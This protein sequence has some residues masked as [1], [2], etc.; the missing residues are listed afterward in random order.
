MNILVLEPDPSDAQ[1]IENCLHESGVQCKIKR[2]TGGELYHATVAEH[3]PQVIIAELTIPRF[4]VLDTLRA[5]RKEGTGP[6]WIIISGMRSDQQMQTALDA[7]ATEFVRKTNLSRLTKIIAGFAAEHPESVMESPAAAS[8]ALP[9]A[10]PQTTPLSEPAPQDEDRIFRQ[11]VEASKDLI[12]ALDLE[13]KRLYTNPAYRG[14]I[15]DPEALKGTLS[16][17]DVH[18]DDRERIKTLFRSTVETGEGQRSEYR[19]MDDL[20]NARIM[21]S[22]GNVVLDGK[23]VPS[24]V[25]VVSRDV[26]AHRHSEDSLQHLVAG[27][28]SVTSEKFFV[29]LVRHLARSLNV[30]FAL[31]SECV[32][33]QRDRVRALGYWADERW[34]PVFEY[35]VKDTTCEAVIKDGRFSHFPDS[36]QELFPRMQALAAMHARSY[37]GIPL[38]GSSETPIGHLFV[39]DDKPLVEPARI[40]YILSLFS[41]RAATE[42]ERM[43]AARNLKNQEI[44]FHTIVETVAEA[45]IVTDRDEIITY[46]N[47]AMQDL[48]GYSSR[49]MLGKLVFSL[50][51]P[52]E[53]WQQSQVRTERRRKGIAEEYE[54]RLRRKDGVVISAVIQATPWY[55]DVHE[56]TGVIG[57]IRKVQA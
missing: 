1:Q 57:I 14:I 54:L 35:D 22:Q 11:I 24:M 26:T 3:T 29:A 19:L 15:D 7:G 55:D 31:V 5:S 43:R 52:E 9:P 56:V 47:A 41:A 49:E 21:E 44:M 4:D 13:G 20:G 50:L 30:R 12:V 53:D 16:F 34:V 42:L 37:M 10:V 17:D 18:P 48:C 33:Q 38:F 39:M 2:L 23:G 28:S 51:L 45:I 46:V 32:G 36:V 25:V 27:T 8:Q 40:K 6:K